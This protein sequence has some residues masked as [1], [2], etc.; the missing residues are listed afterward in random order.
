MS[1]YVIYRVC[2]H[3]RLLFRYVSFLLSTEVEE[4]WDCMLRLIVVNSN[5]LF[6][7]RATGIVGRR[8]LSSGIFRRRE[9]E[10]ERERERERERG[11]VRCE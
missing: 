10:S 1:T 9:R 2:L 7:V 5:S 11:S 8:L 3:V 6:V 4:T